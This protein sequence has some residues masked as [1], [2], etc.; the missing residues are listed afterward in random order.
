MWGHNSVLNGDIVQGF[1]V[2]MQVGENDVSTTTH[3]ASKG[4][5]CSDV[6]M[7]SSRECLSK[8]EIS[9]VVAG[10]VQRTLSIVLARSRF[11]SLT[12]GACSRRLVDLFGIE[13]DCVWILLR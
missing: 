9:R 10:C 3:T 1:K 6:V 13:V 8:R 11:A 5:A 4:L 7:Q 2:R 12:S